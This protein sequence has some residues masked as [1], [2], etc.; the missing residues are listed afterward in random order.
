MPLSANFLDA[1]ALAASRSPGP[2]VMPWPM[3]G[4]P[5]AIVS[6]A[7]FGEWRDFVLSLSLNEAIP[8]IVG[9]KFERAVKLHILAWIDA[10]LLVFPCPSQ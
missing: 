8:R 7:R 2:L 9:A 5:A 4:N 6:F 10:T 3:P 1:V